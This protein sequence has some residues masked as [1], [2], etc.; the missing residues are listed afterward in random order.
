MQQAEFVKFRDSKNKLCLSYW[1][2][3]KGETFITCD[4]PKI[5]K[6]DDDQIEDYGCT[7]ITSGSFIY[8]EMGSDVIITAQPG[9]SINRRPQNSIIIR[10]LEDNTNWCYS[11]HIDTL[12]TVNRDEGIDW[13]CLKTP[14]LLN[15]EQIKISAG[16]TITVVDDDKDIYIANPIYNSESNTISYKSLEEE[17][18]ISLNFGKYL[19]V[20]QG[21]TFKLQST[22]DSYLP[23]VYWD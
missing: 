10:A 22:I 13:E 4:L 1:N 6:G 23:K 12:F 19:K 5:P 3:N 7:F 15:G 16:E 17:S 21:K 18:F 9:D 20:K 14:I 11:V 2:M 8:Q